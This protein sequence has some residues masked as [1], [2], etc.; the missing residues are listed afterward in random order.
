MGLKANRSPAGDAAAQA[1]QDAQ[2]RETNRTR[3]ERT[4]LLANQ[5]G[6]EDRTNIRRFGTRSLMAGVGGSSPL[7]ALGGVAPGLATKS[8]GGLFTALF[9]GIPGLLFG[10]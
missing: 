4:S 6:A 8:K 2:Y 9:G 5:L 10:R 3:Q 7:S 1:A